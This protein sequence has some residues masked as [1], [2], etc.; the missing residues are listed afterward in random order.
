MK[1]PKTYLKTFKI[2]PKS[3]NFSKY[4]HTVLDAKF[5]SKF[6]PESKVIRLPRMEPLKIKFA[7]KLTTDTSTPGTN[8]IKLYGSVNYGF[9][10]T[11]KF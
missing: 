11:A 4:G 2:L 5:A 3:Q 10:V 9:V 1:H 8:S 6:H 7:L